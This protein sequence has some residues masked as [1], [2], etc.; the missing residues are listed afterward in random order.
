MCR[1]GAWLLVPGEQGTGIQ[2][3]GAAEAAGQEGMSESSPRVKEMAQGDW[4]G[5]K[6]VTDRGLEDELPLGGKKTENG[7]TL[8]ERMGAEARK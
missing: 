1:I 8:G 6:Q 4:V 5:R 7:K 3:R 2:A